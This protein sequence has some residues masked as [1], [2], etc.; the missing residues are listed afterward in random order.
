MTATTAHLPT[1]EANALRSGHVDAAVATTPSEKLTGRLVSLDVFRGV[2]I[3]A[4]LL[5]NNLGDYSLVGYFWKHADWK[6]PS[7]AA[8]WGAWWEGGLALSQVPLFL[9]CTLADYVMPMFMLI[10]GIAIPFSVASALKKRN[11]QGLGNS[12]AAASH[13]GLGLMY[14]LGILRR[15]ATLYA[16]GWAIGL[17]MQFMSWR[18]NTNPNAALRFTLG[19][20]V[21]QLLGVSFVVARLIY[22][23]PRTPRLMVACL[24]LL[25][26]WALLRFYPQGD[27]PAGTFTDKQNAVGYIYKTWPVFAGFQLTPWLGFSIAGMLSVPPAAGTMLLGTWIGE[28]LRDT[29]TTPLARVR[30]LVGWGF[31]AAIVGF[32][33]AFDLPMNKPRWTPCYLLY[34]AGI[35]AILS[36]LIYLIVDVWKIRFWT[37]PFVALGVNAIGIYF[38]S[39]FLKI[40]LLNVPSV[41]GEMLKQFLITTLQSWTTP[42][43]GSWVF[44]LSF[45]AVAWSCAALAHRNKLI[46]KV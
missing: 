30:Q 16:L 6:H 33:W 46:W 4:M 42:G 32:V 23:L 5:V 28:K 7:F 39:T 11:E 10:I 41:G 38:L 45:V 26:H 9:H 20:D 25:G 44:T 31:V 24:L 21:L 15:G 13:D 8:D 22:C 19:M 27:T 2:V 29:Q 36:G 18:Y 14:W 17:S 43:V 40:W 12:D 3:L 34:C 35:G 37:T 1:D